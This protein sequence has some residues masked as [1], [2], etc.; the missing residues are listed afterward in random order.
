LCFLQFNFFYPFPLSL[1][2]SRA[3][4]DR[5]DVPVEQRQ[6]LGDATESGLIRFSASKLLDVDNLAGK[7]PKIFEVPFNSTN[8]WHLTIHKKSHSKGPFTLFIKGAPERIL[9]LCTT[10][11]MD[12]NTIPLTSDHRTLFNETY[13]WMAGKG[14]RVLAFAQLELSND[15]YP[16]SFVFDKKEE[17]Y[18]KVKKKKKT[19]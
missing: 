9:E 13:E 16:E 19:S 2:L 4:F 5:L 11:L 6:I 18:P 14:H 8:K 1:S 17:N 12:G 7:Y 15:L 10:I 3:R